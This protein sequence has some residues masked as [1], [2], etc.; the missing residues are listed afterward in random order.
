MADVLILEFEDLG[1]REYEQVNDALGIDM[2]SGDGLPE[3]L[4]VHSAAAGPEGLVIYEIWR[5]R[6]DQERFMAERLGAALAQGGVEGPPARQEWLDLTS[7][8]HRP[9]QG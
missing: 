8:H 3:G 1:P 2:A 6:E 5:S 7:H 9:E 4:I